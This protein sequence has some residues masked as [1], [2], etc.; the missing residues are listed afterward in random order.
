MLFPDLTLA[1]TTSLSPTWNSIVFLMAYNIGDFGGKLI[2]DFRGSFNARSICYLFFS[3]LFFFYTIPLMDK[4][5]TQDDHL[6]NNNVFP[7]F[8]QFLF[9]FTNGFV[10]S[11]SI[12]IF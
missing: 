9:A 12:F 8:N 7:F 3:R 5:F 11:N 10:I 1:K 4:H 6:L 2:A